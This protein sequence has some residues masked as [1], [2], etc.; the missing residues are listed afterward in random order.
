MMKYDEMSTRCIVYFVC[1]RS[2]QII[3]LPDGLFWRVT[4]LVWSGRKKISSATAPVVVACLA[5]E[6]PTF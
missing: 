5:P 6:I 2:F 4:S 3:R 1:A